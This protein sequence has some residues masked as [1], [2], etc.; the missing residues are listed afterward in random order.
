MK[1]HRMLRGKIQAFA[2]L[3]LCVIGVAVAGSAVLAA[4][5]LGQKS[6][7]NVIQ[8]DFATT[9]RSAERAWADVET[10]HG[11]YWIA[12][13]GRYRIDTVYPESGERISEIFSLSNK[14]K[15]KLH[16]DEKWGVVSSTARP[17]AGP[18]PRGRALPI[19]GG[20]PSRA[21][22]Q[23]N[24]ASI[25]T[26]EIGGLKLAGL[27]DTIAISQDGETFTHTVEMWGY[28]LANRKLPPILLEQSFSAPDEVSHRRIT[29]V[30]RTE[31][32]AGIFDVPQGFTVTV[33]K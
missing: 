17:S 26:K 33:V 14:Q 19:P 10:E 3:A 25:G 7:L 13:D 27:R 30:A 8:V 5:G 24:M 23:S 16:L 12:Q 31:V 29:H 28:Q 18:A 20:P 15:V 21:R 4:L 11:T 22:T 1:N 32:E 2:D 9:V 6:R